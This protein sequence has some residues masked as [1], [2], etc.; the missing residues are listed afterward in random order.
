MHGLTK[1]EI[2]DARADAGH[3]EYEEFRRSV[4]QD[5]L[6]EEFETYAQ[7]FF[8]A[9][10][11]KRTPWV[12][13]APRR[14]VRHTVGRIRLLPNTQYTVTTNNADFP[15]SKLDVT[16][17]V[18]TLGFINIAFDEFVKLLA[19]DRDCLEFVTEN[20][21]EFEDWFYTAQVE[22]ADALSGFD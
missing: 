15:F 5:Y 8:D 4:F 18:G 1:T 13:V 11:F 20:N 21:D 17:K 19:Q 7:K 3:E 9:V 12:G 22:R 2:A 10:D 16:V 14:G 6:F